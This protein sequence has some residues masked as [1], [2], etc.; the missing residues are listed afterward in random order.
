VF[1]VAGLGGY[2]GTITDRLLGDARLPSPRLRIVA[3][4]DPAPQQF[5]ERV[6]SLEAK[7]VRVFNTYDAL[8]ARSDVEAVWLPLPIDLHR[9]F[10]EQALAAGKHVVCEKP[11]AG[12][13]DDVDAMIAA[14]DRSGRACVIGFQDAYQPAVRELKRKLVAGELGRVRRASV[15]GCWPRGLNYFARNTW[16][17]RLKRGDTWVLDSPANNAMA[18]F[19]HIALFLLG[20]TEPTA[21]TPDAVEAELYRA[22]DIENY[23]TCTIRAT[24]PGAIPLLVAMTHASAT[25]VDPEVTIVTDRTTVVFRNPT[26]VRYGTGADAKSVP[27][28]HGQPW[29]VSDAIARYLRG[30]VAAPLSTLEMARAHTVLVNAASQATPVR[31]I[32]PAHVRR[33]EPG[34]DGTV[35]VDGLERVLRDCA[36]RGVLLHEGGQ[37]P[38]AA[39]GGRLDSR[40][41]RHFAGPARET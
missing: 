36:D 27:L 30:D 7:G 15:L 38:W 24:L 2:A 41:Y 17:G 39:P 14:R 25:T 21:A 12:S 6:T 35:V 9:P 26:E 22:N 29:V 31:A 13:V 20:Q 5:G 10:T 37:V 4:C 18:H 3:T 8:L 32:P 33:T 40:G 23:D 28:D 34:P 1:G 16:A 11:A 19:I